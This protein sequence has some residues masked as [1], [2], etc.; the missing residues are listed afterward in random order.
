[1][2]NAAQ[3][4]GFTVD[5]ET[6]YAYADAT[7]ELIDAVAQARSGLG[8]GGEL[9]A[10]IFGEVGESSGFVAAYRER[11]AALGAALDGIGTGLTGLASSVRGYVDD[12]VL[13][14]SDTAVDLRRAGEPV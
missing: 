2:E 6:L 11:A 8:A 13:R 12:A 1:M 3:G 5:T 7:T 9:P 10:G 14:D 4:Q